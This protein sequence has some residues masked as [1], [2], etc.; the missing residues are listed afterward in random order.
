MTSKKKNELIRRWHK[1]QCRHV[2][3]LIHSIVEILPK[4]DSY[5]VIDIGSNTGRFFIN[6]SKKI[7]INK[8]ILIEPSVDLYRFSK[9]NLYKNKKVKIYNYG[10][11]SKTKSVNF[12]SALSS[13]K[14]VDESDLNL[15][16]DK[17]VGHGGEEV[18][19]YSLDDLVADKRIDLKG[20]DEIDLIKIDCEGYDY[21]VLEGMLVFLSALKLKPVIVFESA[22]GKLGADFLNNESLISKYNEAGFH[23]EELYKGSS[24]L[25]FAPSELTN[26]D[27]YLSDTESIT[28]VTGIWNLRRDKAG[29]GF[30]RSFDYY[31]ENFIKLLK[32]DVPMYIYIEKEYEKLVWEHRSKTNTH[33]HIKESAEFKDFPFFKDVQKIRKRKGWKGQASWLA[34]STQ[35]TM[36]LYNP[37]VMSKMFMLHDASLLDPFGSEYFLWVDGGLTST[38]HEGYFTK[39]EI[40]PKIKPF[41]DSF[42]FLCFP[43]HTEAEI[44]GFEKRAMDTYSET[45]SVEWVARGGLFGGRKE[46]ISEANGLYY[47]LLETSLREGFMGTEESV[48]TI[49]TYLNPQIYNRFMIKEDGFIHTFFEDILEG[50]A[51]IEDPIATARKQN[52]IVDLRKIKASL[53]VITFNSPEQLQLLLSSYELHKDFLNSPNLTKVL[54]DNSTKKKVDKK[55]KAICKKYGFEH[56]KKGNIGICGGRQLAAEHFDKSDSDYMFF[57]ED[58]MTLYPPQSQLLCANGLKT[59]VAGLYEKSLKI[60]IKENYDFMKLSFTEFFGD[61][62]NQWAWYNV[63]QNKREEYWPD[64]NELPIVGLD[65]NCPNT[66]FNNIKSLDGLPYVDGEIYYCNWPQVV[67][68]E[69]NKKMFLETTW[70]HP[71]EQTWMSHIFQKTKE[72]EIKPAILLASPIYHHREHHYKASERV[73]S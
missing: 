61:N 39:H 34:E 20:L 17:V 12:Y 73:E 28:V 3:S 71:F 66:K 36:E 65:T 6:L 16:L 53:Y 70:G 48:F 30:K 13:N 32:T 33:V 1:E 68:K 42:L 26:K 60:M 14:K 41:L 10:L 50:K 7:K 35:A 64:Y 2:D 24:D 55:Y 29:K 58:D 67:S 51:K 69:G 37:M 18:T 31:T 40:I 21:E 23:C 43:Y 72:G 54:I 47:S 22:Q 57:L 62:T 59:Y 15:G 9:R 25:F 52:K 49:M 4:K 19:F 63:P 5:N 8:G 27:D 56:I 45:K 44:H 38:T 46:F 11:A